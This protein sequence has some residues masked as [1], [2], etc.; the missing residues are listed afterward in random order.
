MAHP[1]YDLSRLRELSVP[2]RLQLVE[3]LWDTIAADAPDAALPVTPDLAAE[4]DRRLADHRANPDAAVPWE[5]V[6]AELMA[7]YQRP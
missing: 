2:E 6:R 4:L 7:R 1:A 5:T 3:D